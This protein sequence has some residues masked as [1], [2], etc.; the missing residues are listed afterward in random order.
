MGSIA[1]MAAIASISV[2]CRALRIYRAR[3]RAFQ[4]YMR[5]TEPRRQRVGVS[6]RVLIDPRGTAGSSGRP[7]TPDS[8]EDG[9]S[10]DGDL[11]KVTQ[12]FRPAGLDDLGRTDGRDDA[13]HHDDD[14]DNDSH[15][16]TDSYRDGDASGRGTRGAGGGKGHSYRGHG[17]PFISSPSRGVRFDS[18][19][20]KGFDSLG[21]KRELEMAAAVQS[22]ASDDDEGGAESTR[23]HQGADALG[24]P[25][26]S[27]DDETYE[28]D[29]SDATHV[30]VGDS[31]QRC[32][33]AV[34]VR[35]LTF[36]GVG[37][38]PSSAGRKPPVPTRPAPRLTPPAAGVGAAPAPR[39]AP[40]PPQQRM[41]LPPNEPQGPRGRL[42]PVLRAGKTSAAAVDEMA[43]SCGLMEEV[44]MGPPS[45]GHTATP[46]R[47]PQ[48]GATD[49]ARSARAP[50]PASSGGEGWA[51][52]AGS[53]GIEMRRPTTA[54]SD[55]EQGGPL[56]G[57]TSGMCS[58]HSS[59]HSSCHS[60]RNVSRVVTPAK[61]WRAELETLPTAADV[62][63][64]TLETLE[65]MPPEPPP[66]PHAPD[67]AAAATA[68]ASAIAAASCEEVGN[69][70]EI[71]LRPAPSIP[72]L[73][74]LPS[75]PVIP[76]ADEV[77]A[78]SKSAASNKAAEDV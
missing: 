42:P 55:D 12:D 18:L 45:F 41:P 21:S 62:E 36:D 71:T 77:S 75:L 22:N 64:E 4:K 72:T 27:W 3:K 29:P 44:V 26:P 10:H 5:T 19:G 7:S 61:K 38:E 6:G 43:G 68:V 37:L 32:R 1:L 20:S 58:R 2:L 28:N 66:T 51:A 54:D 67:A 14:D 34:A 63:V 39:L 31:H 73:P 24:T 17:R 47:P 59:Q 53:D 74:S 46:E 23:G 60:S 48:D 40:M 50:G 30:E 78:A 69:N 9:A 56:D 35:S 65:P 25:V 76:S 49:E 15:G 52:V 57:A 33:P 70:S 11:D 16:D 13:D 8:R